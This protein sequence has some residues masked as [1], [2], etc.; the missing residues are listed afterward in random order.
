MRL[1]IQLNDVPSANHAYDVY[2]NMPQELAHKGSEAIITVYGRNR[3]QAAA[4]AKREGYI[5]RSVNMVG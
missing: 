2:V 1:Q 4:V 5:V 3:N